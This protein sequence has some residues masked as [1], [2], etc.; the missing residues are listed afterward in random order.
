VEVKDV[1]IPSALEDAMSMQAQAER[2]R[3]A[4]V[5]LVDVPRLITAYYTE[6][7]RPRYRNS[8]W[9]LAPPGIEVRR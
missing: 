7:A 9:R 2:E 3:Q 6:R 4:R 5:I 8:G 1:L